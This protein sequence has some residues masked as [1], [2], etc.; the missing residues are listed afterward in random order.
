[1]NDVELGVL[2]DDR[3]AT[4][5]GLEPFEAISKL[6][7]VGEEVSLDDLLDGGNISIFVENSVGSLGPFSGRRSKEKSAMM[8]RMIEAEDAGGC[9]RRGNEV[10]G[11]MARRS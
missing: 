10:T 4:A 3:I 1:M 9:G 7:D 11:R 6:G 2:D 8:G 5:L